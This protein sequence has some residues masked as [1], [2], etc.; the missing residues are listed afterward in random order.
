MLF[1]ADWRDGS[2]L[3]ATLDSR[4]RHFVQYPPP[5]TPPATG[6]VITLLDGKSFA[7]WRM[8][9]RG[10]FHVIDGALQ[11]VPSVDLGMLWCTIPMPQNYVLELEFF[12]PTFRT[13]NGIFVRFRNPDGVLGAV[14]TP[15][16]NSA[17]FRDPDP[18]Y[19]SGT[20]DARNGDSSHRCGIHCQL[21]RKPERNRGISA[22]SA[23]RPREPTRR[24]CAWMGPVPH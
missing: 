9:G 16:S 3:R 23:R 4:L 14:G 11:S 20:A 22:G 18:Q 13:N 7:N 5:A 21:F 12:V 17:W 1:G 19:R 15:F 24:S 10:T 6:T 8:S 2:C